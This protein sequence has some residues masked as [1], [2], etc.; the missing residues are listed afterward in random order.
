M[1]LR[2]KGKKNVEHGSKDYTNRNW[3]SLY[4]YKRIGTRTGGLRNTCIG[5]DCPNYSIVE[6]S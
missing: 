6:I 2:G 4:G 3:C 1:T 5:G